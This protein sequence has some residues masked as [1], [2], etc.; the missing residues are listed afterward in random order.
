MSIFFFVSD[1]AQMSGDIFD[2]AWSKM[3][4]LRP[5]NDSGWYFVEFS[6]RKV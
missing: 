5:T 6:G 1:H 4:A 2:A 3:K